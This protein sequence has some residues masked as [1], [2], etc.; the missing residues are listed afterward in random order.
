[1]NTWLNKTY[2]YEVEALEILIFKVI[3]AIIIV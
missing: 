2:M 3:Y 1:M